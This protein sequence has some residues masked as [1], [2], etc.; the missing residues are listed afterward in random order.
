MFAILAQDGPTQNVLDVIPSVFSRMDTLAHPEELVRNLQALGVVWSMLFL[1]GGLLFML[2]GYR[3]YKFATVIL[4]LLI[5]LFAGYQLGKTIS[6]NPYVVGGCLGLLMAVCSFPL[7]KFAVAALGGLSGAFLGANLWTSV[8]SVAIKGEA[9]ATAA[10]QHWIGALVGLL[11][12]GMLAFVLWKLA[13][14]MFTSVG[15]ATIAAIGGIA[16]LLS[17]HVTAEAVADGLRTHAITV[18]LLVFVPALIG[19]VLQEVQPDPTGGAAP[20]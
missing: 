2:N 11:V 19:L 6:A 7:M 17:F 15:G 16:L 12:F 14:V 13:I 3:C 8:V 20:T 18:P 4:A 9:A 5:G 1:I 10:Q